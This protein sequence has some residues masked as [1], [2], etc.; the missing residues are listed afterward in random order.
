M[1]LVTTEVI[2]KGAPDRINFMNVLLVM[3]G[4]EE[5]EVLLGYSSYFGNF[6]GFSVQKVRDEATQSI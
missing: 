6:R 5:V 2:A 4:I 1:A 3:L